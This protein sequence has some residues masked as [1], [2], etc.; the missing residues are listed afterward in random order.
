MEAE[1]ITE[2]K[3]A[4]KQE[5]TFRFQFDNCNHESEGDRLLSL[6]A[7]LPANLCS[8]LKREQACGHANAM[9]HAQ[10]KEGAHHDISGRSACLGS[11]RS[12]LR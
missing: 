4:I 7:S 12:V 2:R 11:S 1:R 5:P 9:R 8:V 3:D 10:G 6:F